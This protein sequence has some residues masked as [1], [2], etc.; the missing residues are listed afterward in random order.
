MKY[1]IISIRVNE[2]IPDGLKIDL[3]DMPDQIRCMLRSAQ[4]FTYGDLRKITVKELSMKKNVGPK[5]IELLQETMDQTIV[6]VEKSQVSVRFPLSQLEKVYRSPA[7]NVTEAIPD[8]LEIDSINFPTRV[9][10]AL[11]NAKIDTYG[12]LRKLTI[13]EQS[14]IK[15]LGPKGVKILQKKMDQAIVSGSGSEI[16]VDYPLDTQQ[17]AKRDGIMA[18]YN[19]YKTAGTLELAGKLLGLSRGRVSQKISEGRELG[20]FD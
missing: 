17:Q 13:Q 6:H 7:V 4:I 20:C 19:A 12:D 14:L 3:W 8:E 15:N 5:R 11:K 2:K 9:A 1:K 16:I 18:A 10:N